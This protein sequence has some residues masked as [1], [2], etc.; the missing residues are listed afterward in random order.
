M[1]KVKIIFFGKNKWLEKKIK[2]EAK[3]QDGVRWTISSTEIQLKRFVSL[4][5]SKTQSI[6]KKFPKKISQD[7]PRFQRNRVQSGAKNDI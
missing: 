1:M 4:C 5:S 6:P 7:F 2:M 3:N